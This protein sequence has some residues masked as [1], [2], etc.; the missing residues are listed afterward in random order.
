MTAN[1]QGFGAFGVLAVLLVLAI[2]G[3]TGY[4]AIHRAKNPAANLQSS[5]YS[6]TTPNTIQADNTTKDQLKT[7]LPHLYIKE[8]GV[9]LPLTENTKDAYYVVGKQSSADK[10][11]YV[12]LS[13]HS[14]DQYGG[15]VESSENPGIALLVLSSQGKQIR[16]LE[17][18]TKLIQTHL[19]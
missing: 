5:P 10:P 17:T 12:K 1:R 13:V 4:L 18:I 16:S 19:R 7:S 14:L 11:P 2:G 6:S 8:L 9:S 15:C 3:Y